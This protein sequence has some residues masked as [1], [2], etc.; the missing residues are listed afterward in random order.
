MSCFSGPLIMAVAA[1]IFFFFFFLNMLLPL[2]LL[3]FFFFKA[4]ETNRD[5][6]CAVC[7]ILVFPQTLSLLRQ[8]ELGQKLLLVQQCVNWCAAVWE[9]A[10]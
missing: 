6:V 8:I 7:V 3:C 2:L 1:G 5:V 4:S 10:D 9:N